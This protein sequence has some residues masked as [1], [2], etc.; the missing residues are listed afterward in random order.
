MR[1]DPCGRRVYRRARRSRG[2]RDGFS[3]IEL[4]VVISILLVITATA[5]PNI[6]QTIAQVRLRS[7]ANTVAGLLQ[8][9][10]VR[11]VR[12]N[13]YYAVIGDDGSGSLTADAKM[14]CVD[15]NSNSTC[16]ASADGLDPQVRLGGTNLLTTS[17]PPV[18]LTST[19]SADLAATNNHVIEQ[20]KTL[21]VYFN[22]RGLPC[23]MAGSVCK[24]AYSDGK[25]IAY[26]YY[27]TDGRPIYGWAA[28]TVSASGR[29]RVW[30]YRGNNVWDQ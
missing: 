28:V 4:L 12:D 22:S 16:S 29:V 13:S 17:A 11:A 14:A 10:R 1:C 6:M 9:G 15:I 30:M 24:N 7:A 19:S 18:S 20:D 23:Y 27:I 25:G 26:V 3:L 8:Q 2:A 21:R 5:I